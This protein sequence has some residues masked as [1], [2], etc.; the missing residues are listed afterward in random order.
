M[1]ALGAY[2]ILVNLSVFDEQSTVAEKSAASFRSM[3]GNNGN[4]AHFQLMGKLR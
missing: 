1:D 2:L 3:P 4:G